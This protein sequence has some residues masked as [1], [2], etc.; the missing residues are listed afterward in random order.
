MKKQAALILLSRWKS[1][2]QTMK[3]RIY[4]VLGLS[5][6]LILGAVI[7]S[8]VLVFKMG[9]YLLQQ[10]K[11]LD[12]PA[13]V[14]VSVQSVLQGQV[15]LQPKV[16][17]CLGTLQGLLAFEPWVQRPLAHTFENVKASCFL[18]MVPASKPEDSY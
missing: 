7:L 13:A 4:I 15:N 8:T 3:K 6:A 2:D 5:S 16:Q 12:L 11:N 1:M 18:N 9:G 17:S 10:A 14:P